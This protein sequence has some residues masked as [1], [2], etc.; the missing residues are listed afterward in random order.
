MADK[1]SL[2]FI[3]HLHP[4]QDNPLESIGGMQEVSQQLL[5][6]L[7]VSGTFQVHE[8]VNH[9]AWKHIGWSTAGYLAKSLQ[10]VPALIKQYNIDLIVCGSMVTA[11][12]SP[13]LRA[14]GVKVPIIAINHGQDVTLPVGPYQWWV[15]NVFGALTRVISVSEATSL[16]SIARGLDPSKADVLPNGIKLDFARRMPSQKEAKSILSEVHSIDPEKP[17]LLT[18]GRLVERKGHA[19]FLQQVLS[20]VKTPVHYVMI[21]EGPQQ[22]EIEHAME[23]LKTSS[24]HQVSILGRQDEEVVHIHY[25]ASDLFIMP[26]ISVDGDMEGFGIVLLEANAVGCPA[27]ATYIEGIRDVI[28]DGVNGVAIKERDAE[29]F[30]QSIDRLLSDPKALIRLRSS[31][32]Q[33]AETFE[34][35]VL[36]GRYEQCF[37]STLKS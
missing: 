2:L 5:H 15:P 3:S 23:S 4:P 36:V 14:L 11:A 17:L 24:Q 37:L 8:W 35:Q 29:T 7:K 10:R 33:R 22:S 9:A 1:P 12:I 13:V 31:S 34:W 20:Q 18:V 25:A 6:H 27:V 32:K 26:N 19:W 28:D 16:Q 30:A 21:G